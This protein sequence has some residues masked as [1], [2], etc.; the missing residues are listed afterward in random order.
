[1]I[2]PKIIRIEEG[3]PLAAF[4]LWEVYAAAVTGPKKRRPRRRLHPWVRTAASW[5]RHAADSEEPIA[6]VP[7]ALCGQAVVTGLYIRGPWGRWYRRLRY[8]QL[9]ATEAES[10]IGVVQAREFWIACYD[11]ADRQPSKT[12]P[13]RRRA[14][15][16]LV[17]QVR[18]AQS[19]PLPET[20]DLPL[21]RTGLRLPTTPNVT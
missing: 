11:E 1:M 18:L 6:R 20:Q 7:F 5:E 2:K 16:L 14:G 21:A 8:L 4:S 12:W 13:W 10:L 15:K 3:E 9:V 17:T 19:R